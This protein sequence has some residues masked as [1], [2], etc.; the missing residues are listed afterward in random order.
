MTRPTDTRT[1]HHVRGCDF[2]FPKLQ[3]QGNFAFFLRSSSCVYRDDLLRSDLS[4][5]SQPPWTFL[6]RA[7]KEQPH[8][9]AGACSFKPA[10]AVFSGAMDLLEINKVYLPLPR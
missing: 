5:L 9:C 10:V 2:V 3:S 8:E 7:R 4:A 1:A 6:P